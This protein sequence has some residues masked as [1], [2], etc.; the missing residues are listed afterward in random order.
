MNVNAA[1]KPKLSGL[2]GNESRKIL[3]FA[4]LTFISHTF[5]YE[6]LYAKSVDLLYKPKEVKIC[7]FFSTV[8][9]GKP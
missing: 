4:A 7:Q 1:K 5:R 2:H 3:I 6:I 8:H 9:E